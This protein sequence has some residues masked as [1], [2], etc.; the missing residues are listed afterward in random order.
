MSRLKEGGK[1]ILKQDFD[2]ILLAA[3][4]STKLACLLSSLTC[5]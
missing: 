2:R 1:K 3:L 4:A 5:R